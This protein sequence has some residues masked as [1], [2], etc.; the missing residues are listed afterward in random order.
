[1]KYNRFETIMV[2]VLR[3]KDYEPDSEDVILQAF[4]VRKMN[5]QVDAH[6]DSNQYGEC[7][8]VPQVI[9]HEK[10]GHV[11]DYR[12]IQLLSSNEWKFRQKELE[13][14]LKAAKDED[15]DRIYY[16]DYVNMLSK[17]LEQINKDLA[18]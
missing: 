12:M 15:S 7:V 1:M 18:T 5:M 4:R 6:F 9:D 14:F 8:S 11:S 13:H 17:E 3:D 16:Q 2:G 10:K